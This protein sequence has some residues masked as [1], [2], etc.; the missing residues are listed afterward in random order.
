[1]LVLNPDFKEFIELLNVHDVEYLVVGGYAVGYH[2]RPRYTG[3]I[4]FWVAATTPNARKLIQVLKE[5]G[6][7]SLAITEHDF[8]SEEIVAIRV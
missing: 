7:G 4:D 8:T 3:D 1:M 6:L 5:F 2:G